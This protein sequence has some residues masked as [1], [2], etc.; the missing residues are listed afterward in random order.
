MKAG[1]DCHAHVYGPVNNVQGSN[2]SPARPAPLVDWQE[3]LVSCQLSG[4]VLVQPSFLGND[5]RQLLEILS[6]LDHSYRGVVQLAKETTLKE[7]AALDAAGIVGVRWNL[8]EGRSELPNLK[9]PQWIDFL[10]HLKAMDWHL[11]LHL[12]GNRLP[13]IFPA[14]HEHGVKLVIDHIGLPVEAVPMQDPGCRLILEAG[15]AERTWVKLSAPYRSPVADLK[16]HVQALLHHLGRD[17]L[18]WGSDWPWTRHED[19]H[20]YRDTYGWLNHWISDADDRQHI[21]DT[22]PRSLFRLGSLY[23]KR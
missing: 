4:G 20:T 2:Y 1:F 18:V 5:N 23:S 9:D 10:D 3:H 15:Q 12:E 7:I 22:S 6:K 17:K 13:E 14:L 8:I 19:K 11:E 21:L 16:P